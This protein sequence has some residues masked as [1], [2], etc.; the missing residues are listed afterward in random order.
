M[1]RNNLG[2]YTVQYVDVTCVAESTGACEAQE[3]NFDF[4]F[5]AA[6]NKGGI[7]VDLAPDGSGS[8]TDHEEHEDETTMNTEEY[9]YQH[10]H[11][12]L[13]WGRL[14]PQYFNLH[15]TDDDLLNSLTDIL[16]DGTSLP[17][18]SIGHYGGPRAADSSGS[19]GN[20]S[21]W[22]FFSSEPLVRFAPRLFVCF[23][24]V[25]SPIA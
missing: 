19:T 21:L 22:K 2:G 10:V 15:A 24:S 20:V 14:N 6:P 8:G 1:N 9:R 11:S 18:N 12:T 3:Q 7:S 17:F 16:V 4:V 5:I 13:V 23:A 25:I